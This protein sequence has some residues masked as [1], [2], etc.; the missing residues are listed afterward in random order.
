MEMKTNKRS[1]FFY[2]WVIIA[3]SVITGMLVYGVRYSFS[4]FFPEILN[5]F[6]W[7]RGST[8]L[9]MSINVLVYGLMAPA[10][11]TLSDRWKPKIMM[12]AGVVLLALAM[13]GCSFAR[14]LWHF[15]IFFGVIAP[16]GTALCAWPILSPA[17][18]NWFATRR[19]LVMGIG[20]AGGGLSFVYGLMAEYLILCLG[21]RYAYLAL[22][23]ILIS[24][25]LPLHHFVFHY[26][27]ESKGLKAYGSNDLKSDKVVEDSVL[28]RNWTVPLMLRTYQLWL[29]I[30]TY[31]LFWGVSCFLV[32]A[33]Q[34]KYAEDAGYSAVF[35]VSIFALYGVAVLLGQ[36]SGVMSDRI[37]REKTMA[38]SAV[39][40]LVGLFSLIAVRDTSH[41]W[42]LY[43]Y[44][45]GFGYGAGLFTAV[46]NAG[47][48]DI[49]HG[50][51][52]GLA[53]GMLLTGMGLGGAIGPWLGGYL[54]DITGSYDYAL[55]LCMACTVLGFVSYWFAAPR[56]ADKLHA[57][58]LKSQ[59]EKV[60]F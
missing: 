19:G 46:I 34:I 23:F 41:P 25:L 32:L 15:Y 9:M 43:I 35:A 7:S 51:H 45:L 13:V 22:A 55:I 59:T 30:L 40:A 56:S 42:L 14:Q 1:S 37:G 58:R 20:Q 24:I 3:V 27:P 47:A 10:V 52:F 39:A 18:M 28:S 12:S 49:F 60:L 33:H 44:A 36:L 38:L 17:L 2:G 54:Y 6:G 29:L 4:I 11:G 26:H 31:F 16:V 21:W 50:K 5:E 57:R 53:S 8:A 48:A